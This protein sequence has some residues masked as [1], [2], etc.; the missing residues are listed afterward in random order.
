MKMLTPRF[1]T[2]AKEEGKWE[3]A[4]L[5]KRHDKY[6]DLVAAALKRVLPQGP[7]AVVVMA[8]LNAECG[9]TKPLALHEPPRCLSS[10]VP[11]RAIFSPMTC[12]GQSDLNWHLPDITLEWREKR[13]VVDICGEKETTMRVARKLET[14]LYNAARDESYAGLSLVYLPPSGGRGHARFDQAYEILK[15]SFRAIF[16]DTETDED[17]SE[18]LS[19]MKAI[20]ASTTSVASEYG[21][22]EWRR[23]KEIRADDDKTEWQT[24]LIAHIRV[25]LGMV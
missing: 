24:F 25:S 13:Y 5:R 14:Y 15:K 20:L 21:T 7:D 3:M 4:P 8:D 22:P 18:V 6:V 17:W 23:I 11:T 12:I 10:F 19:P 2:R 16:P 1:D 9:F